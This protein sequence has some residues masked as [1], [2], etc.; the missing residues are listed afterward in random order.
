MRPQSSLNPGIRFPDGVE[1]RLYTI[2]VLRR[3]ADPVLNALSQNK[4]RAT[5]P[6]AKERASWSHLEAVGRLM[7]GMAPW[8][9]LGVDE[10][11]EGLLRG[12]YLELALCCISNAV[13]PDAQDF[14]NFTQGG[15]RLVDASFLAHALLRSPRQLWRGLSVQAQSNLVTALEATRDQDPPECNWLL[16]SAMVEAALYRFTGSAQE[17]PILRA[18]QKHMD[19]YKGDG[20][21]GDGPHFRWDGYNGFVIQP[22]LLDVAM[23]AHEMGHFAESD[24]EAIVSRAQ[25][26]ASVQ[27]QQISPEGTSPVIGRSSTYRFGVFQHLSQVA[28]MQ[29]LPQHVEIAAVRCGLTAVI[30]RMIEAPGTFDDAGWLRVGVMGSQPRMAEPYISTGSLYLCAMGLLH[31]GLPADNPFW[32]SPG[33][34]WTQLRIWSGDPDVVADHALE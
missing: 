4:L 23:I 34:P 8:L 18:I 33:C 16:F 27:E 9:E 14:M 22:M 1:D 32:S 7:A 25:R 29:K 20:V 31:L 2:E 6:V 13:D 26:F 21:Y 12:Q 24:L 17:A 28:L 19:W 15:Q 30:R 3:I 10:T 11:E 5:M